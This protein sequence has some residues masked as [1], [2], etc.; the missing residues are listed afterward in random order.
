VFRDHLVPL[1]ES[2][3]VAASSVRRRAP[4]VREAAAI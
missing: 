2:T 4:V 1:V 3:A